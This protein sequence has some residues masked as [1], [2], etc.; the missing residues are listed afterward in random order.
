[1]RKRAL[2]AA[3]LLAASGA[4]CSTPPKWRPISGAPARPWEQAK[5]ICEPVLQSG[6]AE[7]KV[8]AQYRSCLA[9]QGWTDQP[10]SREANARERDHDEALRRDAE[11]L[12]SEIRKRRTKN[13][14]TLFAGVAPACQPGD[15]GTEICS[16]EW[17]W[18]SHTTS[19]AA[20]VRLTCI[21]AKNGAPRPEKS[22]HIDPGHDDRDDDAMH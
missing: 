1:M 9:E 7:S 17:T 8:R 10:V 4:G 3:V 22:C 2:F 11:Q 12:K 16:W 14:L 6:E 5:A 15:P 18:K 21:L 13:E 19:T 20:P